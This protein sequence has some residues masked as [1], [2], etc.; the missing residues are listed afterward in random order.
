[1]NRP[2]LHTWT[3]LS[4]EHLDSTEAREF[5]GLPVLSRNAY[6]LYVLVPEDDEVLSAIIKDV[7]RS[8]IAPL[9]YARSLGV[10]LIVFDQ[11]ELPLECLPTYSDD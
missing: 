11:D 5:E 6:S 1:M 4:M 3:Y 7:P 2:I 8:F 10:S 9:M